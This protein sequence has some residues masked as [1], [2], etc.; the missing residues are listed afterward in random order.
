M[1][2]IVFFK[3]AAASPKIKVADPVYN[4]DEIIKNIKI[5]KEK[6]AS[7]ICFPELGIT[8]Y[9]C[10]DLFLQ[11]KLLSSAEKELSRIVS[12]CSDIIAIAGIPI[13]SH[14]RLFNCAVVIVNNEIIGVVPKQ[15][16]PNY[17]EYYEKR[18]FARGED[19]PD[20]I[21]L[22]GKEI[23]STLGMVF[24]AI[25]PQGSIRYG[26]EI[27]EDLWAPEPVSGA[28]CKMG[29]EIIFNLSASTELVTKHA[30]RKSLIAGQSGRCICAYV[31][32]GASRSESTTDVVFSGYSAI[33]ENAAPLKEGKRFED[34]QL[35][36]A[37]ID[38]DKLRFHR[39]RNTTFFADFFEP[40]I[41]ITHKFNPQK[42]DILDR[43]ISPH[44]FVPT[45]YEKVERLKEI[46]AIQTSSLIKRLEYIGIKKVVIG[47]SGGV[48]SA[49]CLL[50]AY[51]A[52]IERAWDIKGII[53]LTM[54]GFGTT[55]RTKN[56]AVSLVEK[57]D[58]TLR[59]IDIKE[60]VMQH[61][62]DIGH[63]GKTPDITYE[64]AQARERTQ[65][66]MDVANME[67]AIALGTGD[68][69]ELALGWCTYNAD[70]MSMYNV[71]CSIPKT[72]IKS[73]MEYMAKEIGGKVYDIAKDILDTPISPELLPA[74]GD[75]IMQKTEDV[76]GK[77]D[78]H[79]FFLYHMLEGGAAPK[80]LYFMA[81]VA[82][83]DIASE[84][85][86]LKTL[87]IFIKRFFTQQFKRSAMPD[88]PKVGTVSLSPRGDL[89]MPSDASYAIWL[90]EV[91]SIK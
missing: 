52:F 74:D 14:G 3:V 70:H 79:D 20:T 33:F 38:I 41:E 18:W 27:C 28:L 9:S 40:E 6:K 51:R 78:L 80:K 37:D 23:P 48:D 43:F 19:M 68:L 7:I 8:G 11:K 64:N 87:K 90:D 10:A 21:I 63:D 15:Y 82:F 83:K 75:N 13:R 44:P 5:A 84:D 30:Y 17:N 32:A 31:Y 58:C 61:L 1:D 71:N 57:L 86:I 45:G 77:Y 36:T 4:A 47:I 59:E 55:K 49:L 88:G 34:E 73:L 12:E 50:A 66:I 72:L 25:T 29:C 2:N 56:N 85:E 67:G 60:S 69:S 35:I 89:R 81:K 62:K 65:I 39:A 53:A 26:I 76:L 54:P 42:S 24:K 16:I 91:E 22:C 46:T